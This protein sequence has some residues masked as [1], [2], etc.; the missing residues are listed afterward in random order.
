MILEI[1]SMLKFS[2][3]LLVCPLL[4]HPFN[5]VFGQLTFF[6]VS[7]SDITEARKISA[8]QQFEIHDEIE[9]STTV[10]YGLG[11]GWEVGLNLINLDYGLQSKHFEKND[12]STVIPYAPL[13]LANAQ[14]AFKLNDTFSIGVGA[15]AGKNLTR[16][17]HSQLV[18]YTYTNLIA[19]LGNQD[20]YQIVAGSYY[21]NHRYLSDGP[22]YGFQTGID[23]GLWY[24]K[25][26][27]LADWISGSNGK[28]RLTAG[29]EVF[30]TQRLPLALGWQRSNQD[31]SQGVV[32]QLTFLPRG[33]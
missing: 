30:L 10:T 33:N 7:S 32:L 8:Q 20:Q 31:G 19:T 22:S 9:S 16:N 14:K 3:Y 6:N 1:Q 28:G 24:K 13:L 29:F 5:D 2:R 18:Y 25:L 17:H 27:F 21:G 15:V 4:F 23:A 12:T 26:H 11:K